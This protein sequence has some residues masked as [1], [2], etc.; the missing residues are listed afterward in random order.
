M[1]RCRANHEHRV[2]FPLSTLAVAVMAAVEVT[3]GG[4]AADFDDNE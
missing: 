2:V 3:V 4:S 1:G